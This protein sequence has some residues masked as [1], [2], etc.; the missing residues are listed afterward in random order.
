MFHFE[1]NEVQEIHSQYLENYRK[2]ASQIQKKKEWKRHSDL[3][4]MGAPSQMIPSVED[5]LTHEFH[6][7][8]FYDSEFLYAVQ[9]EN[10]AGLFR[11]RPAI[12]SDSEG[13]LIHNTNKRYS[14]PC[15]SSTYRELVYSTLESDGTE[16]LHMVH[17]DSEDELELTEGDSRDSNPSW[18]LSGSKAIVYQSTGIGR[19][20]HG[21]FR[22]LGP[23]EINILDLEDE[24]V[25]EVASNPAY[26]YITPIMYEGNVYAI[27]RPYAGNRHKNIGP[28][29]LLMIPVNILKTL[30]SWIN[31]NSMMF[32]GKPLIE[33]D[34]QAK[35]DDIHKKLL[36]HGNLVDAHKAIE[37]SKK[38][39]D[40]VPA[41]VPASWKLV[42]ITPDGEESE[43]EESV[44]AF[45]LSKEGTLIYSNGS[46]IF[47]KKEGEK[48]NLLRKEQYVQRIVTPR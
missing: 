23:S 43:I 13:H 6:G 17:M 11:T 18:D 46:A 45:N 29:A 44:L 36:L 2:N 32:R 21:H 37:A 34:Q 12:E 7:C 42:K 20:M 9:I 16:N 31:F 14:A 5:H 25:L 1:N 47:E 38:R 8:T 40:A 33:G 3:A 41:L 26:D 27:R 24:E 30:F 19:D 10:S 35:N 22:L 4:M 39:G 48:R 28:L 15:F